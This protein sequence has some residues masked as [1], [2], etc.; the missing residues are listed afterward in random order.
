MVFSPAGVCAKDLAQAKPTVWTFGPWTSDA[1]FLYFC[2]LDQKVSHMVA[3]NASRVHLHGEP[4]FSCD[5]PL[6]YLEW[7]NRKGERWT[8][9]SDDAAARS[10]SVK[11]MEASI[12]L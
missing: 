1:S 12:L 3:C 8:N 6:Q 5:A 10:L 2:V 4:V 7:L 9:S 11:A